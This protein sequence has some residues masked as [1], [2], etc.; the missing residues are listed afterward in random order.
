VAK[1]DRT[2]TAEATP[3]EGKILSTDTASAP[4]EDSPLVRAQRAF[5]HGDY[6]ELARLAKASVSLA[7]E[8][9]SAI[10]ALEQR[11]LPSAAHL[12]VL[13]LVGVLLAALT[14]ITYLKTS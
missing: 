10:L 4:S 12:G 9:R 2:E 7:P 14:L 8:V 6:A 11:T 13:L 5:D 1:T 3:S